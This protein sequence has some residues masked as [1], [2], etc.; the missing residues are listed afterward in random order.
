MKLAYLMIALAGAAQSQD[1]FVD[2]YA[3]PIPNTY[4]IGAEFFGS[5]PNG[6]T[7]IASIW[8]DV[9]VELDGAGPNI[10]F[11]AF[12][13][14]YETSLGGPVISNGPTATFVGNTNLFFGT[15]D[16]SNP[17]FVTAFTY[18]GPAT[19]L[20]LDII[21]QNSALFEGPSQPFGIVDLYQDAFGNPGTLFIETRFPGFLSVTLDQVP[22]IPT[23]AS[24]AVFAMATVML[25]NSRRRK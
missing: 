7:S 5:L 19:D 21:G 22:W 6:A 15:P 24:G 18:D 3:T 23:P 12:N 1:M 16:P 8:A 25:G 2:I 13:P 11:F 10:D 20:S 17:L 4:V 14:A 9:G